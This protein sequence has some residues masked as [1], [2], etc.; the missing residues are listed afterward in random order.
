MTLVDIF[1]REILIDALV[2]PQAK[3]KNMLT[4]IHGIT[5][6][7]I[8][9]AVNRSTAIIGRDAARA[10]IF[11]FVGP[12]TMVFAHG[13]TNDFL[14]LRWVH[15]AIVDTREVESRIKRIG[16]DELDLWLDDEGTGLEAMC[17]VRTGVR[18]RSGDGIHDSL[19]DAMACRELAVWYANNLRGE[20][21]TN[22]DVEAGDLLPEVGAKPVK[23]PLPSKSSGSWA[24][25]ASVNPV[26][27]EV[28][29]APVVL[30]LPT[31]PVKV[32]KLESPIPTKQGG[33][34]EVLW[35]CK[36]CGTK[37]LDS[38]KQQHRNEKS[39]LDRLIMLVQQRGG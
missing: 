30:A 20:I 27:P 26:A 23:K 28:P 35:E 39:H 31:I 18:I 15:G 14:C 36:V 4:S 19:E 12:D 3:V 38:I 21:G 37:V 8:M 25:V 9:T 11:E 32:V 13:G 16:D 33:D 5:Y 24:A 34:N 7:E 17:R 1:T 2:K 6:R 22:E 29:A 10:K